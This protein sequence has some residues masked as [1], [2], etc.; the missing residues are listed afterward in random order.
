[1]KRILVLIT[2]LIATISIATIVG[3][4]STS[5]FSAFQAEHDKFN[6]DTV[7][8]F[9][10]TIDIKDV[11]F[12]KSGF[13]FFRLNYTKTNNNKVWYI[14]T[15]YNSDTWLFIQT[16]SFVV[17]GKI[18][19]FKSEPSPTRE[20]GSLG[21]VYIQETNQFILSDAFVLNLLKAQ[22]VTLR[23]EGEHYYQDKTLSAADIKN[24][25]W[26]VNY[27]NGKIANLAHG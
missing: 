2:K 25:T 20:I 22:A 27:V 16:L 24:M 23:L 15:T 21:D 19:T 5:E 17:D 13:S 11:E 9:S 8:Y 10:S 6:P 14:S 7:H 3:C 1:M 4:A 18:Y 26:F 12:G